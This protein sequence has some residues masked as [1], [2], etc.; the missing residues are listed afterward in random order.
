MEMS[1]GLGFGG[2]EG[3]DGGES[4]GEGDDEDGG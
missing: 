1:G 3:L 4:V 2:F